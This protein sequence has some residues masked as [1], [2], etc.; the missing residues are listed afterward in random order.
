M[1]MQKDV[2]MSAKEMLY[3]LNLRPGDLAE[4]AII[5]GTVERSQAVLKNLTNTVKKFSFFDYTMYNGEYEGIKITTGNG[6]RYSADS[7]ICAEILCAAGT[8]NIIRAGSCGAMDEKIQVGDVVIVKDVIR[9]DG[10]TPYYVKEDFKSEADKN[11]TGALVKACES[12]GVKYHLGTV[13]VTDALLRETRELVEEKR[14]KGAI[15]VDMVSSTMLTIAKLNQVRAGCILAVSDNLIT[16][17]L[18]FI[19]P[20]YYDAES[21]IVKV[22]LAAVKTLAGK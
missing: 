8:K 11:V 17:E 3:M 20:K 19:N 5:P 1:Q 22:S 6:G 4:Y 21:S 14:V 9:G 12:L 15:A 2:H 18:G 10:V 16:G 7:A 13:W